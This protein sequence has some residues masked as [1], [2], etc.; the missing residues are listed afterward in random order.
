M[1][2]RRVVSVLGASAHLRGAVAASSSCDAAGVHRLELESRRVVSGDSCLLQFALPSDVPS[3]GWSGV[4]LVH[5]EAATGSVLEKSYSPTSRPGEQG[6]FE[7]LV[8]RYEPQPGGG[9]GAFLCDL[10]PGELAPLKI[11]SPRVVHG[12]SSYAGRWRSL[13]LVAGGTGVA[14]FLQIIRE[15]LADAEDRTQLHLLSINRHE[16]DILMR[17][18]LDALAAAHPDRLSVAYSLTAPPSHWAGPVGRGSASIARAALPPAAD[19]SMVLVCGTDGFVETWAG[20]LERV[21]A[22]PGVRK[23]KLQGPVGGVLAEL[24]YASEQVYKY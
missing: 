12:S 8:K 4:K 15:L 16:G 2:L 18:E 22:S 17:D 7:L 1:L 11:K 9:C 10:K 13:G 21:A 20:A 5:E 6:G 24:G 14:P 23:Q 3:L 19:G